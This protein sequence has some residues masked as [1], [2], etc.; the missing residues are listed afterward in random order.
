[1]DRFE[2]L[3]RGSLRSCNYHCSYCPFS[4]HRRSGRELQKDREQWEH[5]V[6]TL[7]QRFGAFSEST[8]MVVPYGEALIHPWYWEGLARASVLPG[9]RAA[10]AQT[11]LS[12]PI[13]ESLGRFR[14]AGGRLDRLRLWGTFH[15]EMVPAKVFAG[16]CRQLLKAGVRMCAGAVG[17]PGN[18]EYIEELRR[19]LPEE[20]YLWINRMD[21]LR[22]PYTPEEAEAFTKIDPYFPRELSLLPADAKQCGNRLFVE[23]SGKL[24]LCN[25]SRTLERLPENN[26]NICSDFCGRKNCSCYLAY[27]GRRDFMNE[28]LFGPYPVFRIPRR[29]RAVFLD[30]MGTLLSGRSTG[31]EEVSGWIRAGLEGLHRDGVLLFFATTLPYE[32]ARKRCRGI[33]HLFAG[34][35]FAG[36]AHLVLES[37]EGRWESVLELQEESLPLLE[38]EGRR[39]HCRIRACRAKGVLCKVTMVRPACMRWEHKEQEELREILKRSGI[40]RVRMLTEDHCLQILPEEAGK[41]RG[42]RMICRQLGIAPSDT[43]AAG[44]SAEDEKMKKLCKGKYGL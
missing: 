40:R 16:A 5:F 37:A 20:I 22:R 17:V 2:L 38:A 12:F 39:Y 33:R 14:Q 11:N 30:I 23:G 8:L 15:P 28:L 10:G 18:L 21:G 41:A 31:R 25:I 32:E 27:G 34:G 1:M 4:K 3:Y 6:Q 29:A 44:D 7:E 36:G 24:R 43:A 42:V 13:E 35:I 19:E 9:I 26:E